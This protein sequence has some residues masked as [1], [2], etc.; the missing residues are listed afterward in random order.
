[1]SSG[2]KFD[3]STSPIF[4]FPDEGVTNPDNTLISVVFPEPIFPTIAI[5]F[6]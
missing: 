3:N 2:C 4:L 1:M 5:F 6:A